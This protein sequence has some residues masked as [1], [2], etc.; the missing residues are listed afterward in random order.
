MGVEGTKLHILGMCADN[1]MDHTSVRWRP[2]FIQTCTWT[3]TVNGDP[4]HI[5]LAQY[6]WP[7]GLYLWTL[8]TTVSSLCE[9]H[10]LAH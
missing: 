9:L 6:G 10:V 1:S 4:G 3:L 7:H 5:L 2:D 8:V